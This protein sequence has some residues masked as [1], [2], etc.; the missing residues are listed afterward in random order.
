[1][2]CCTLNEIGMGVPTA[3]LV[4]RCSNNAGSWSSCEK[5][6]RDLVT[7][8]RLDGIL[9]VKIE[10]ETARI[11]A[12]TARF[13]ARSGVRT[14]SDPDALHEEVARE[15]R[16]ERIRQ[17]QDEEPWISGLKKYLVGEIRDL[18]QEDAKVF[19]SVAV[20]YEV[21]QSDLLFYCPTTKES[22]GDRDKLMRLEVSETLQQQ[23][24]LHHYHT[25]LQGGHQ[26]IGRTYDRIRDHFHWG[27]L[28]KSVYRY[29]GECV[30]CETSK[31]DLGS[32]MSHLGTYP[33]LIIAIYHIPSLPRSFNGNTEPLISVD[34]FSAYVMANAS[35]SRSAQTIAETYE[36]CVFRRFGA[37]EVIR[38]DQEPGLM[39]DFFKYINKIL[40]QRQRA[41]MV[42]R[43]QANGSAEPM[44]QT[45]TRGL[46]QRDWD[47]YAERLTF[48]INT[49]RDRIRGETP[50]YMIHGWDPR[51]TMEA[52]VP[53]G[54][55][56]GTIE[57]QEGGNIRCKSI[58]NRLENKLIYYAYIQRRLDQESGYT[59]IEC[60]K[61]M[62]GNWHRPFHIAEKIGGYAMKLEI[63]ESTH[64]IFPVVHVSN[65]KPVRM[66]PDR[67]LAYRSRMQIKW[68]L[69]KPFYLKTGEPKIEIQMNMKWIEFPI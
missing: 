14:G 9:V 60:V 61:D 25:S 15:L 38:R 28:C 66:F 12:V 49:T 8:N 63:T 16:I 55:L 64:S 48:A 39:S 23:D 17:A 54:T 2:S 52:V 43:P 18:T 10:D 29:V 44:V 35:V 46:D 57:I 24:I 62:Q 3:W 19:G 45:T 56:A 31:D 32:R 6:I 27:G 42:Y 59:W 36:E 53:V 13:K 51:S 7:L 21:D 65:I 40:C 20:N 4:R 69:M 41:T 47:E 33:F 58:T 5:D 34:L 22:A 37:S 26:G 50:F 1:M 67:P 68:I 11:S 30:D